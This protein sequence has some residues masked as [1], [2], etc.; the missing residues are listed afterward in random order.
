MYE[1]NVID[2]SALV[3]TASTSEFYRN[4]NYYN[5]PVGGIHYLDR[6][7]TTALVG[8]EDVILAFDGRNNFRHKVYSGYKAGRVPNRAVQMQLEVLYEELSQCGMACYK[9]DTFE[10]DDIVNWAVE[11]NADKY[12]GIVILGNDIDLTHNVRDGVRFKSI[13][14]GVNSI[15]VGNFAESIKKGV[16]IPF[17]TVA[18]YKVFCGCDSDKIPAIRCNTGHTGKDLFSLY[19]KCLE[20]NKVPFCYENTTNKNLLLSIVTQLEFITPNEIEDIKR[21]IALVFPGECPEGELIL[22]SGVGAVDRDSF[23]HFLSRYG[24]KDSTRCMQYYS[25]PTTEED[26]KF[27]REKSYLLSSGAYAVDT[28]VKVHEDVASGECLFLKEF[29]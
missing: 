25:M 15:Y 24:D 6:Y 21:N 29:D 5:F 13:V 7:L 26:K 17:N 22:G 16:R 10:G 3:Y 2:V 4:R 11:Q 12:N 27:L 14:E 28:N 1:L 23:S 9:Y 8:K 18:V 19:L 20:V